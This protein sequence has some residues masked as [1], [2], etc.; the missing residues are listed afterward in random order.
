[1][2]STDIIPSTSL[3]R[4][5]PQQPPGSNWLDKAKQQEFNFYTQTDFW[6][7]EMGVN[8]ISFDSKYKRPNVTGWKHW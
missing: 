8:V 6:H 5:S 3:K 4:N 2:T 7:Y 1:M